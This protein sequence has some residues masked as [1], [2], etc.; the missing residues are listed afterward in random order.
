MQSRKK[1]EAAVFVGKRYEKEAAAFLEKQGYRILE[2]NYRCR[3]GEIDLIA[4]NKGYLCFVE[5]KYRS[6]G[7]FGGSLGAVDLKKQRRISGAALYYLMEKGYDSETSCRFD[8]VGIR[9]EG[10][11]LIKNAFEFRR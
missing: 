8:V 1:K 7:E 4:A 2:K 3:K 6:S 9:T 5:V 10:V 11:E